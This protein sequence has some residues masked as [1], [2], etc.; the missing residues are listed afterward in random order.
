MVFATA[1]IATRQIG[2]VTSHHCGPTLKSGNALLWIPLL[3]YVG[4]A[5]LLQLWTLFEIEE[6]LSLYRHAKT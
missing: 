1:A 6:V 4:I 5:V 2:Y 3:I